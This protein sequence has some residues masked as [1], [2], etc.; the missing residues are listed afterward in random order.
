MDPKSLKKK[1]NDLTVFFNCFI[2]GLELK[3]YELSR[4]H[5]KKLNTVWLFF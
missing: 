2:V 5:K 3:I 4:T 1:K